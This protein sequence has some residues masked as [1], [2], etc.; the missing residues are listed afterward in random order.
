MCELLKDY[1]SC[2]QNN[3][4]L[5]VKSLNISNGSDNEMHKHLTLYNMH[6]V[7]SVFS[8]PCVLM[9]VYIKCIKLMV[10]DLTEAVIYIYTL[11]ALYANVI[12]QK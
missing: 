5:L 10:D 6:T 9:K 4:A 11:I 1:W 2:E 3:I 7:C 8:Y 12:D